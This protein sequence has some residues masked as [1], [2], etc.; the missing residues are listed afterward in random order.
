MKDPKWEVLYSRGQK[1]IVTAATESEAEEKA[2]RLLP[3]TIKF[4]RKCNK[5]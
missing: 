5:R 1:R 4:V 2:F 3:T